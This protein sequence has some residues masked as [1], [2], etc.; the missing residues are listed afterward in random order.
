MVLKDFTVSGRE[1]LLIY[2]CLASGIFLITYSYS[3]YKSPIIYI[4]QESIVIALKEKRIEDLIFYEFIETNK[5]VFHFSEE[6][7][8]LDVDSVSK[9]SL[10]EVLDRL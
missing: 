2:T 1:E 5:V 7:I 3:S 8:S 4:S 6:K 10:R 9:E